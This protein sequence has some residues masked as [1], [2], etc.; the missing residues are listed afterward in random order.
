MVPL[1]R[2]GYENIY[3]RLYLSMFQGNSFQVNTFEVDDYGNKVLDPVTSLPILS[4]I[5]VQGYVQEIKPIKWIPSG[6][7][8]LNFGT[9]GWGIGIR[10]EGGGVIDSMPSPGH[11]VMPEAPM[12]SSDL[13]NNTIT[14][15][16][17]Y[18]EEVVYNIICY[19]RAAS[20]TS[21]PSG[22]DPMSD[23]GITNAPALLDMKQHII[24][25]LNGFKPSPCY[26]PLVYRGCQRD[27]NL[28]QSKSL[29]GGV[30]ALMLTFKARVEVPVHP[31]IEEFGQDVTVKTVV[32]TMPTITRLE[33]KEVG[34]KGV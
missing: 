14:Q 15:R 2:I 30:S 7:D 12:S 19:V 6:G 28:E 18:K 26:S 17:T 1:E 8:V 32:Y 11:Q 3:A 33:D 5:T 23:L 13:T 29:H 4:K 16:L 20:N 10:Y 9:M 25:L 31:V 34:V 22:V 27:V 21:V 24:Y